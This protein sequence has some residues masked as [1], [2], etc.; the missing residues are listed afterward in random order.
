MTSEAAR[1]VVDSY[2]NGHDRK[3]IEEPHLHRLRLVSSHTARGR[4]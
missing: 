4:M 3:A 1:L 2:L